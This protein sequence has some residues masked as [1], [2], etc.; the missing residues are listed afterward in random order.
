[1]L[2]SNPAVLQHV[3]PIFMTSVKD[4]P[5][6]SNQICRAIEYLAT[7]TATPV[8]NPLSVYFQPL[9]QL[10]IENAYRTDF[11]GSQADLTL[12]SF[13]ALSALCEGAAEEINDVLYQVLIPVLQLLEKTL[14]VDM[15]NFGEKRAK[16]L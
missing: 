11:E 1:M 16:D 5:R 3:I 9:F 4:K 12:A 7:S 2:T 10:L 15:Q 8:N 13:A 14:S 6:I